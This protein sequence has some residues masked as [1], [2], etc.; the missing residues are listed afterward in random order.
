MRAIQ[1]NAYGPVENYQL[2]DV[3]APEAG[4][5]QVRIKVQYAGM[6]WGDVMHRNGRIRDMPPLPVIAGLEVAGEI[7]QVGEDVTGLKVGDK[8]VTMVPS[9]GFAEYAVMPALN[10][11]PLDPSVQLDRMLAYFLNM[12][13]AYFLVYRWAK[14]REG[15]TVLLHA[16]TGGVGLLAL[17]ILKRRF[18]NVR[19]IGICSSAEKA[20]LLR[21]NG[22]DHIVD[23]TTQDY[24]EEVNRICGPKTGGFAAGGQQGG[25][26]DVALNGVAGS[27]IETDKQVVR[28]RGRW[29]IFGFQ[30][31]ESMPAIDTASICYDGI[32]IM[33]FSINAWF[34]QPEMAEAEAFTREWLEGEELNDVA[35]W[36]LEQV[37]EASRAMEAGETSGKVVIKIGGAA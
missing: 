10:L 14:V 17:Q 12:V 4:P 13:V 24:V 36:P 28:K 30:G 35:S 23:R 6:R 2:V 19:V 34:G 22:C 27:T 25:G 15:E 3:P 11:K 33:P 26:V 7:D 21:V 9:G 29:V 20:D 16:A 37:A 32:T 8:V 31:G 5:G 18:E 1:L